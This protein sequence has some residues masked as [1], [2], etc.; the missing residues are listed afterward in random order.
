MTNQWQRLRNWKNEWCSK[1]VG[2]HEMLY[3]ERKARF[4]QFLCNRDTR[5]F[6][7]VLKHM[8]F[9]SPRPLKVCVSNDY[10]CPP[11]ATGQEVRVTL[12]EGVIA[13]VER[14]QKQFLLSRSFLLEV[15]FG[16]ASQQKPATR[17]GDQRHRW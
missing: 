13:E 16:R 15:A 11:Q 10:L 9:L 17:A 8:L 7:S 5:S 4:V 6:D 2:P 14:E 3:A 1:L 12:Q